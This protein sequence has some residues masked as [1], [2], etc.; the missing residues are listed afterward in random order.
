MSAATQTPFEKYL[1]TR[2]GQQRLD[3]HKELVETDV[4]RGTN[5]NGFLLRDRVFGVTSPGPKGIV[6]AQH[7]TKE[8]RHVE[9]KNKNW[10]MTPDGLVHRDKWHQ[11]EDEKAV[12]RRANK[13]RRRRKAARATRRRQRCRG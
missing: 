6:G 4:K 13:N 5:R 1:E 9:D 12:R 8:Q 11:I 3:W 2:R 10:I 7:L